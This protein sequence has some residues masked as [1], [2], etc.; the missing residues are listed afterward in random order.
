MG[1]TSKESKMNPYI[2]VFGLAFIVT[3]PIAF[4]LG[5]RA[6]LYLLMLLAI[7]FLV[8]LGLAYAYWYI[9]KKAE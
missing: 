8:G 2:I 7:I 3:I 5:G 1:S 4:L 9:F 6:Y